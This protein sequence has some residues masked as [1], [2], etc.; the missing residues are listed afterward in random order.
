[1]KK[2]ISL[3]AVAVFALSACSK[4][5]EETTTTTDSEP[6][7]VVEEEASV[8]VANAPEGCPTKTTLVAKSEEAGTVEF[9]ANHSWYLDW[10]KDTAYGTF[11]FINWDGFDPQKYSAREWV[12]GDVKVS[13]DLQTVDKTMPKPGVWNYRKEGENNKLDWINISTVDLAGGVFDDNGKVEITYLGT[14]Y[15]C[16]KVTAKDSSSSVEGEFIAK[17]HPWK[18]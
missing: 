16:G 11:Y 9:D 1:M 6:V 2:L 14:D 4:P 15:V 7:A 18:F 17:Y 8:E 10:G 3:I 12:E 5:A 13:F